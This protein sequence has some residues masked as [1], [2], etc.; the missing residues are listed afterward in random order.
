M[1]SFTANGGPHDCGILFAY[2]STVHIADPFLL[3]SIK[4]LLGAILKT[5]FDF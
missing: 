4:S 1:L 3:N 2:F 5:S